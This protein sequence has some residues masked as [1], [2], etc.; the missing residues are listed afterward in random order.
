MI[1]VFFLAVAPL[2]SAEKPTICLTMVVR[3]DASTIRHCLSSVRPL[4][5]R[6][7]IVDTGS[8]D[9]TAAII[10][11]CLN[12]IPGE[13][14]ERPSRSAARNRNEALALAKGKAEYLLVMEANDWLEIDPAF[15]LPLLKEDAYKM[16]TI[17]NGPCRERYQL[18]SSAVPWVWDG[19]IS[20]V[21]TCK[22]P[23][24]VGA[25]KGIRHVINGGKARRD[26]ISNPLELT[27]ALERAVHDDPLN[28]DFIFALAESYKDAGEYEKAIDW[29]LKR[30]SIGGEEEE[31][32]W[33]A[34]QVAFCQQGLSR[35][36]DVVIDSFLHAFR[37]RPYRPEP[38]FH[39]A[40]IY[41][42]LGRYQQAYELLMLHSSLPI[43]PTQDNLTLTDWYKD[44]GLL[45]ELSAN[46]FYTGHYQEC[47]DAS[48][49]LL[50]MKDLPMQL[51]SQAEINRQYCLEKL[52]DQGQS[53]AA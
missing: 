48:N 42:K 10:K 46:A 35:P 20:A 25:L 9:G 8:T 38:V 53:H 19:I 4:I 49:T 11:E 40:T 5:D 15:Q 24:T 13:L 37:L 45:C 30:L 14:T 33:S 16:W 3:N 18:I 22:K 6:W 21:I 28:I 43:P 52:A 51:R 17:Y 50:G 29:Y 1:F 12:G 41:R 44:Y 47:L 2:I 26:D 23:Y 27:E 31:V 34:L 32:F 7:V 39:L 36:D